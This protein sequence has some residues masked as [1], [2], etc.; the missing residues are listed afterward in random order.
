MV[1]VPPPPSPEP[2]GE[3]PSSLFRKTRSRSHDTILLQFHSRRSPCQ[4]GLSA[5][6][7]SPG[8]FLCSAFS[9]LSSWRTFRHQVMGRHGTTQSPLESE[10]WI[11]RRNRGDVRTCNR[12]SRCSWTHKIIWPEA[13]RSSLNRSAY[14]ATPRCPY[15]SW[16]GKNIREEAPK[17]RALLSRSASPL[18]VDSPC[19]AESRGLSYPPQDGSRRGEDLSPGVRER[20]PRNAR[21]RDGS[22]KDG[23]TQAPYGRWSGSPSTMG[24]GKSGSSGAGGSSSGRW[25][26]HWSWHRLHR[27]APRKRGHS[28]ERPPQTPRFR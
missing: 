22:G 19:P 17:R 3:L 2:A 5:R 15:G 21:T 27:S 9:H 4:V 7:V 23:E 20:N 26:R 28:P 11:I 18:A 14:W 13:V 6:L 12:T 8:R 10:F 24:G 1:P 25:G 16:T